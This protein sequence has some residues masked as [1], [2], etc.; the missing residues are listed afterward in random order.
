VDIVL[1]DLK[2]KYE[3]PMKFFNCCDNKP[4]TSIAHD[5]VQ[6]DGT[7][8]VGIDHHF[9]KEMLDSGL[10]ATAYVS[11]RHSINDQYFVNY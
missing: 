10:V 8:H 5:S 3:G 11:S 4:T 2:I 7:K 6:R 9:I 1:N